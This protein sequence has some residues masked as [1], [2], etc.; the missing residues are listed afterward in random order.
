M[1]V[2][3]E[4]ELPREEEELRVTERA[5]DLYFTLS[6]LDEWLRER[7]KYDSLGLDKNV[8]YDIRNK[9]HE[10]MEERGVSL[11]ILS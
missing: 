2:S 5:Y 1:I 7:W 9:L 6:D 10:I 4:F 3:I 8:V 11:D